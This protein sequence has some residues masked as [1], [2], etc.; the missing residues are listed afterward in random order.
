[1]QVLRSVGEWSM[2]LKHPENS[3]LEA[4]YK[5]IDHSKHYIFIENQFFISKSY[6]DEHN[7]QTLV[8][9]KIALHIVNRILKAYKNKEKFRVYIFIPLLPGFAGEPEKSGTLQIILK[10]T[11]ETICRNQGLSIIERLSDAMEPNGDHWEDYIGFFS[12]RN[13]QLVNGIPKT[14]LIYIHSKL[15]IIDDYYVICGSANI[16]DRSMKGPRDSE[17]CALIK[18][19][20]TETVSINGK[21]YKTAKFASSLRK[22][23]LAEHLGI[24]K[25]DTRLNDPINDELHKLLWETAR[26]NTDLYRQIFMCYPD[27]YYTKFSMIPN[28]NSMQNKAQEFAL[29]KNYEEKKSQIIGH[30]VEFPLHFLEEEQLG[31]S[32]FSKENLVPERNFT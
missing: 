30:I 19:K 17:F 32:F 21:K 6:E 31:I 28:K 23:L 2:G 15:M 3:I 7:K 5:L 16:N 27:D 14:E 18:E 8:E 22:A 1:M 25:N 24:N 26:N 12:L 29:K 10:Y 20:R 13:H 11:F 4:Y 9:N